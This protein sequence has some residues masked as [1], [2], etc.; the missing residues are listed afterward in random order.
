MALV[1]VCGGN[2]V[3]LKIYWGKACVKKNKCAYLHPHLEK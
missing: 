2:P 3:F 1:F